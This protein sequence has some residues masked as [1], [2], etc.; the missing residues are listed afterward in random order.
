MAGKKRTKKTTAKASEPAQDK[1]Q[2]VDDRLRAEG[3]QQGVL[4]TRSEID[5]LLTAANTPG[6]QQALE[7]LREE[8]SRTPS[9][10]GTITFKVFE[11]RAG[12]FRWRAVAGNGEI[13]AD[14]SEGYTRSS[15]AIAAKDRFVSLV[16]AMK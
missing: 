8:F 9:V 13:M 11:D 2:I 12:E 15:D 16:K 3:F 10:S 6:A 4:T 1:K 5:R 14:S 7:L